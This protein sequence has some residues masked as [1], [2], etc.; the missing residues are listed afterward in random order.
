MTDTP[1]AAIGVAEQHGSRQKEPA[2]APHPQRGVIAIDRAQ[3]GF[4]LAAVGIE[5]AEPV[6]RRALV[7][8]TA[9]APFLFDLEQVG[10]LPDVAA[11]PAVQS[12]RFSIVIYPRR[13]RCYFELLPGERTNVG[14][15]LVAQKWAGSLAA[16]LAG[17]LTW[18]TAGTTGIP[19][20]NEFL[21]LFVTATWFTCYFRYF[22][23]LEASS[24]AKRDLGNSPE[25]RGYDE[26]RKDLADGERNFSRF[27]IRVLTRSLDATDRFLGD[28]GKA[29]LQA[30]QTFVQSQRTISIMDSC[31]I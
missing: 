23:M 21:S 22:G 29:E 6:E 25:R 10:V 5:V 3:N 28:T 31:F 20:L 26:L 7:M 11:C 18:V 13:D 27:Y 8:G 4:D 12:Y 15:E 19:H 16:L 2:P 1:L 30:F 9:P 14:A 24:E 17:L